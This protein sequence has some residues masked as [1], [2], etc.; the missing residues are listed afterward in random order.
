MAERE[1]L[2]AGEGDYR[3]HDPDDL[4]AWM[5]DRTRPNLGDRMTTAAALASR[6]VAGDGIASISRPASRPA[7]GTLLGRTARS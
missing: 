4:R 3:L 2:T 7:A 6:L 5:R 1:L